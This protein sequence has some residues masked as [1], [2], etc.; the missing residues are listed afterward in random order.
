MKLMQSPIFL[1]LACWWGFSMGWMYPSQR[2]LICTLIPKGQETEMMGLFTF[3]GQIFGWLPPLI[4]TIMN[5]NGVELRYGIL[6]ITGFCVFAFFCTLPMGSYKAAIAQVAVDSADKLL[7]VCEAAKTH[8][9]HPKTT[10]VD[11]V[12]SSDPVV[13]DDV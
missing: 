5:E 11:R 8:G 4:V 6:V 2:V 7:L 12:V 3:M 13:T 10:L 1:G 9:G